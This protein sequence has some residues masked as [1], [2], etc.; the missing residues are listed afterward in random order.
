MRIQRAIIS[1][2]VL[3]VVKEIKWFA[4]LVQGHIP[5]G[6]EK[7]FLLFMRLIR[8]SILETCSQNS[9]YTSDEDDDDGDPIPKRLLK[10]DRWTKLK[11]NHLQSILKQTFL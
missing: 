5:S 8:A 2:W 11:Q 1:S 3:A 7:K 4:T 6:M 9:K 10:I